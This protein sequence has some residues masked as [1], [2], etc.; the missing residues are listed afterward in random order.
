MKRRLVVAVPFAELVSC[1]LIYRNLFIKVYLQTK[2]ITFVAIMKRPRGEAAGQDPPVRPSPPFHQQPHRRIVVLSGLPGAGKSTFADALVSTLDQATRVAQDMVGGKK[3]AFFA[4]VKEEMLEA[5]QR[6]VVMDRTNQ[7]RAD[8][9]ECIELANEI[10]ER[11]RCDVPV[12]LVV[13][14]Y[15]LDTLMKRVISRTA[16][17]GHF[18]RDPAKAAPALHRL[19][20]KYEPATEAEGFA[21]IYRGFVHLHSLLI[22]SLQM[23]KRPL[24]KTTSVK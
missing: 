15:S 3:E 1:W 8:R 4:S 10:A 20:A 2:Q 22:H 16:H 19:R 13:F 6:L 5:R 7:S 9:R 11:L 17:E 18:P 24:I 21:S 12:D 23:S 14:D